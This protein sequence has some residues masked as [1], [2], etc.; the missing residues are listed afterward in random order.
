MLKLKW[1]FAAVLAVLLV[2]ASSIG[3]IGKAEENDVIHKDAEGNV[4]KGI[5]VP[6]PEIEPMSKKGLEHHL[7][8][9]VGKEEASKILQNIAMNEHQ[10]EVKAWLDSNKVK[11]GG[12]YVKKDETLVV[13][14][15]EKNPN[16]EKKLKAIAAHPEKIEV[17][18]VHY[19][20]EELEAKKK[21]VSKAMNS[22]RFEIE[23][24]GIDQEKNKVDVY[25]TQ[26]ALDENKE[27]I[28]NLIDEDLID[29]EVT[30][31]L[32]YQEDVSTIPE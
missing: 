10:D 8:Q 11:T 13:Q 25:I 15:A 17:Q 18:N 12:S 24:V 28:Q 22:G 14:L 9:K 31:N 7:V 23:A 30:G 16:V 6:T 2:V 32:T 1:G 27:E 19:S 3:G 21:I 20:I 4:Y 26:E 29:W 5:K